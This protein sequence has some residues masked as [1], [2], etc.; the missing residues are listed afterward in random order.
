MTA[1]RPGRPTLLDEDRAQRIIDAVKAGNYMKVAASWAGISER[2]LM[3]WL[4][5]GRAAQAAVDQHDDLVA[6]CPGECGA[7]RGTLA[8]PRPT[9]PADDRCGTC[10]TTDRPQAWRLPDTEARYLHFL[11]EVTRAE[12]SAEVAAVVAWRGAFDTDW[13]AARDY[14]V[15]RRPDRWAATTRVSMTT[16]ESERRIDDALGEALAALAG[17]DGADLDHDLDADL[18]EAIGADD[19]ERG[20][21]L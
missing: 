20:P 15:R 21:E 8:E 3:G 6:Y 13:R 16:E 12:T 4:A 11:H 17:D 5:R 7:D 9:D 18:V 19:T 1:D 14:L 10:G 2:T